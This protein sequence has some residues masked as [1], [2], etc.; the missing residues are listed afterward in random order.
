MAKG[1][2]G[3]FK[4]G[5]LLTGR[6][7]VDL[8]IDAKAP[9]AAILWGGKYPQLPTEA[10]S[11]Q[12]LA[13]TVADLVERLNRFPLDEIGGQIR[14]VLSGLSTTLDRTREKIE[15]LPTQ[16]IGVDLKAAAEDLSATLGTARVVMDKLQGE[17]TDEAVST[18]ARVRQSLTSMENAMGQESTL[19]HEASRAA[20]ELGDAA[21]AIRILA[22]YLSRHP[23]ALLYGK[24]SGTK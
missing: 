15:G 19:N 2:R 10:G 21:R 11:L 16:E 18:L 22:D 3:K 8:T 5:N 14:T 6:M 20:K 23:E 7:V 9:E 13:A 12:E 1:L 4:T 17:V 24:D